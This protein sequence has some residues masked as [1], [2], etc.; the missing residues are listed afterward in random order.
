MTS[1]SQSVFRKISF[2]LGVAFV[3]S[4]LLTIPCAHAAEDDLQYERETAKRINEF[5]IDMYLELVKSDDGNIL[6]SPYALY[7]TLA[8]A[9]AGV[10]GK[11]AETITKMMGFGP[12]VRRGLTLL[13]RR[14]E[15]G[16]SVKVANGIWPAS[17]TARPSP[18]FIE[19]PKSSRIFPLNF[20]AEPRWARNTINKWTEKETDGR[21]KEIVPVNGVAKTTRMTLTSAMVFSGDID[22]LFHP[23]GS[24]PWHFYPG[25]PDKSE[26]VAIWLR[27]QEFGMARWSFDDDTI[28]LGMPC[29]GDK[30]TLVYVIIR[31][32]RMPIFEY[33]KT[34]KGGKLLLALQSLLP[35]RSMKR[36]ASIAIPRLNYMPFQVQHALRP[37]MQNLAR[38]KR[39]QG[40]QFVKSNIF[41][42]EVEIHHGLQVKFGELTNETKLTYGESV[43]REREMR[44]SLRSG[45]AMLCNALWP[46]LY[47]LVENRTGT[48]LLMGRFVKPE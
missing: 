38:A 47:F 41:E 19:W 12:D 34:L 30:Y 36:K 18:L 29:E 44:Q 2:L 43:M 31:A 37:T 16:S 11:D 20:E 32:E 27:T 7:S 1:F 13:S 5:A 23:I 28:L 33:E 25:Y 9:Y 40:N 26:A 22:I 48:I 6:F 8:M 42:S 3:A 46:F 21:V 24:N 35:P 39:I 14:I 45:D 10:G 15:S 4:M 17:E